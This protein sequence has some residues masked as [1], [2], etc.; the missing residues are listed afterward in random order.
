MKL[1][2]L[3]LLIGCVKCPPPTY[4]LKYDTEVRVVNGFYAGQ[5]GQAIK[6]TVVYEPDKCNEIGYVVHIDSNT[7]VL[8]KESDLVEVVK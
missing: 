8:I 7:D 5:T 6:A 4:K 2:A 3:S 1:L